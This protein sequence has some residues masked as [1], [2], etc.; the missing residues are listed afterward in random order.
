[1][2]APNY[3][4]QYEQRLDPFTK[5]SQSEKQRTYSKLQLHDRATLTIVS[6]L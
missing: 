6:L 4:E 3:S 1:M 5:F 2:D